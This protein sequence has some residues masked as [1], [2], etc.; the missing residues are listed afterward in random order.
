ML[1]G[2]AVLAGGLDAKIACVSSLPRF[3]FWLAVSAIFAVAMSLAACGNSRTPAPTRAQLDTP[4]SFR[5]VRIRAAGI[6]LRVPLTWGIASQRG[7]LVSTISF[8]TAVVA[9]W[10][11]PRSGSTAVSGSALRQAT[12]RLVK[13]ARAHDPSFR[14]TATRLARVG[15]APTIELDALEQIGTG[16]RQ[17]RS[18]HVFIP[19]AELVFDEYAPPSSF[20]SVN[21]SV[22]A[23][24]TQSVVLNPAVSS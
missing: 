18:L 13:A 10:R 22:F 12:C 11:Y 3:R 7:P 16:R 24:I 14:V 6:S 17:V 20:A 2:R 23:P 9:I 1:I 15:G 8:G 5:R 19:R 21:G 4:L